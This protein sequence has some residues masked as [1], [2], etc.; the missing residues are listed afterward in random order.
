MNVADTAGS[1]PAPPSP[2]L[3]QREQPGEQVVKKTSRKKADNDSPPI[4]FNIS[5][6]FESFAELPTLYDPPRSV[7]A[8]VED[9]FTRISTD[10]LSPFF[11]KQREQE[12]RDR[13][14]RWKNFRE[15]SANVAY[16]LAFPEDKLSY[17]EALA[18]AQRL[19]DSFLFKLIRLFGREIEKTEWFV[20]R[21]ARAGLHKDKRFVQRYREARDNPVRWSLR[22]SKQVARLLPL[23]F[24][25]PELRGHS[26]VDIFKVLQD[27][28][29]SGEDPRSIHTAHI[30]NPPQI[31][32]RALRMENR[33]TTYTNGRI[34]QRAE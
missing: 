16:R 33:R 15:R 31:P 32:K 11:A 26:P 5:L 4:T 20:K 24:Y 34:L 25:E 28:Y 19:H 29:K 21:E 14:E 27:A 3:T 6:P 8:L 12:E 9:L 17:W 30:W 1:S 13:Q 22:M 18:L 2:F 7:I 23:V 10:P